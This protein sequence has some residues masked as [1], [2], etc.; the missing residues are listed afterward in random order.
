MDHRLRSIL[1]AAFL[2]PSETI[3]GGFWHLAQGR[4]ITDKNSAATNGSMATTNSRP[5]SRTRPGQSGWRSRWAGS[6]RYMPVKT[7]DCRHILIA[8]VTRRRTAQSPH[9]WS[10]PPAEGSRPMTA[11]ATEAMSLRLLN[12]PF[13]DSSACF[14]LLLRSTQHDSERDEIKLS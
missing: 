13:R 12:K 14:H 9:I 3:P 11:G 10:W 1:A 8:Q 4:K 6:T 2:P 5:L 7:G